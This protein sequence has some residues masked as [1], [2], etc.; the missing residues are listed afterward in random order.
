MQNSVVAWKFSLGAGYSRRKG[1]KQSSEWE[2]LTKSDP[3]SQVELQFDEEEKNHEISQLMNE[4]TVAS[5]F[6]RMVAMGNA[7]MVTRRG[8]TV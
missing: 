5:L 6:G 7:F 2:D 3:A 4:S 1:R 8:P